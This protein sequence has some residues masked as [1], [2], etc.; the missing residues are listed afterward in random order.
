MLTALYLPAAVVAL[1]WIVLAFDEV[2]QLGLARF[3]ILP[4]TFVGLR[5]IVFAPFLHGSVDHLLSNTVPLL[6]L[7]WF[8]MYF[9]PKAT[10]R[11][12]L[13]SWFT[14]G[15]WV[16]AMG[17]ESF[18]IG[19]SGVVYALAGFVFF[20][21]V[22]RRR[23]ALMAVS[24]IVVFLYGGMW[25]GVLP[26]QPQVSW[27]S[28]LFGGIVGGLLAWFYRNVPPA[29][30]PPPRPDE[31]DDDDDQ[32]E[33]PPSNGDPGDEQAPPPVLPRNDTPP[34]YDPERTDITWG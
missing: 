5:G 1:M 32:A 4:R 3:G 30:V 21:G 18:H 28:H 15:L 8:T 14:T 2:Y 27:E 24:L 6:V 33:L 25:W 17:R 11:V 9:Y 29:H 34:G 10:G 16:W 22:I 7:G 13:V 12:V 23:I 26:I 19:A 20:S 31:P